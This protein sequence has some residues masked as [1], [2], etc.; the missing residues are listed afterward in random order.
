MDLVSGHTNKAG[1]TPTMPVVRPLD[2]DKPADVL[3]SQPRRVAFSLS[4]RYY[5]ERLGEKKS[6]IS[7]DFHLIQISKGKE[8]FYFYPKNKKEK[9]LIGNATAA[10]YDVVFSSQ[11]KQTLRLYVISSNG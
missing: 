4:H 8:R 1:P 6:K 2:L 11:T 5:A 9:D 7:R 3:S 10:E